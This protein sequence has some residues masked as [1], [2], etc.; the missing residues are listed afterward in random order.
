[1]VVVAAVIVILGFFF[2]LKLFGIVEKS[3]KVVEISK[4]SFSVIR[5]PDLDDR[6]KE[7]QTQAFAKELFSLFFFITIGSMLAIALPF[8]LI[9][10]MEFVNLVKVEDVIETTLSIEC[11]LVTVCISVL[12]FWLLHKK[13]SK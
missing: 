6:Q 4:S 2:F 13:K 3:T 11:I 9:W 12:Y 7:A 8:A 1:M 10:L 5:N